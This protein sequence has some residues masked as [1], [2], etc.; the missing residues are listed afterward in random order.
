MVHY[1]HHSFIGLINPISLNY[2]KSPHLVHTIR[3][4]AI[5][6]HLSVVV[7][8]SLLARLLP[9]LIISLKQWRRQVGV[10][11]RPWC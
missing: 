5:P 11:S 9:V 6:P 8:T 10:V 3:H 2:P 4:T 7:A 1:I